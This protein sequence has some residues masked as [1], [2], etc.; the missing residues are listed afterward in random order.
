MKKEYSREER[1]KGKWK[2]KGFA[3]EERKEWTDSGLSL[4]DYNFAYYLFKENHS[5]QG[6]DAS[7]IQSLREEYR[8]W[9]KNLTAQE[10]LDYFYPPEIRSKV[11]ELEQIT[12]RKN[13]FNPWS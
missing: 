5:P 13:L 11:E 7:K 10:W 4:S 1:E 8:E 9:Q 3:T 12:F 6:I 2:E